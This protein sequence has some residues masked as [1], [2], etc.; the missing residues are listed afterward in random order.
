MR[1]TT[2][3]AKLAW[4]IF[5]AGGVLTRPLYADDADV[6]RRHA[7]KAS[8]LAAKNKC[9][10]A[11]PEFTKAFKLLKDPTLLFNRAECYRKIG[12]NAD[13]LKDYEQFLADMP[14]AP[15]RGSVEA[16]IASLKAAAAPGAVA[17]S[18]TAAPSAQSV[19][20]RAPAPAAAPAAKSETPSA[21]AASA[22]SA[23]K[24]SSAAETS[25]D[26][27]TGTGSPETPSEAKGPVRHAQKWTD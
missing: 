24:P 9:R 21:A 3:A 20:P 8:Q 12:K 7:A 14:A 6:G 19:P 4:V 23:A 26:T 11:V 10:V 27:P 5:C 16:R 17:T 15:N 13:A 2:R 1:A 18:T 25:S 22:V